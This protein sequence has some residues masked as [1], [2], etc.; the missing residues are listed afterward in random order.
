MDNYQLKKWYQ[1]PWG[2]LFAILVAL[3]VILLILTLVWFG[4]LVNQVK[5][6]R[7]G[8]IPDNLTPNAVNTIAVNNNNNNQ[9]NPNRKIAEKNN[10]P[11]F[12]NK[13]AKLVVVEFGDFQCPYC[14]QEFT[15]IREIMN[16]YKKDILFIYRD[17]PIINENSIPLTK[18]SLCANEQGKYWQFF[19]KLYT[20]QNNIASTSTIYK[21]AKESGLDINKLEICFNSDK[22]EQQI[23]ENMS[24]AL[25]LGIDGTP[26]FFINGNKMAGPV[27]LKDWEQ[28]ITKSL[29]LLNNPIK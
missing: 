26:T 1:T 19:D 20:N 27:P 17:Y 4:N 6:N 16:K 3:V 5:N 14:A 8:I 29:E 28:V 18:Y 9:N 24:D 13:N 21:M 2:I 23:A 12:G 10:R 25:T 15:V 22:Y 7:L 11:F